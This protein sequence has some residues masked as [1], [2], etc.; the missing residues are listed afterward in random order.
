MSET[1][2]DEFHGQGGSYI[3]ENGVRRRVEAPTKDHPEG[4]RPRDA[5][6]KPLDVVPATDDKPAEPARR[7]SPAAAAASGD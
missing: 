6:G 2:P 5:E 1:K 4:N 3:V 7:R